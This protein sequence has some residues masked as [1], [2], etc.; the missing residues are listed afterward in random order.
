MA[1][2]GAAKDPAIG[3]SAIEVATTQ[4]QP[5]FPT[6]GSCGARAGPGPSHS[7]SWRM[8]LRMGRQRC[9]VR[10]CRRVE[11]PM[12]CYTLTLGPA[13]NTLQISLEP[14]PRLPKRRHPAAD[15]TATAH[16]RRSIEL[17]GI[18]QGSLTRRLTPAI[19]RSSRGSQLRRTHAQVTPSTSA[20]PSSSRP[21]IGRSGRTPG[22]TMT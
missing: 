19:V 2:R 4:P 6:G 20:M 3:G 5:L 11:T 14:R 8:G 9:T 17:R 12:S 22:T 15:R 13:T 18:A 1:P 10:N 21:G 7:R 16:T